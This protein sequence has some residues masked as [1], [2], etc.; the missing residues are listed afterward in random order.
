[1]K[2]IFIAFALTTFNVQ[3]AAMKT[4]VCLEIFE[5]NY[6]DKDTKLL[7]FYESKSLC[8]LNTENTSKEEIRNLKGKWLT[9]ISKNKKQPIVTE[10]MNHLGLHDDCVNAIDNDIMHCPQGKKFETISKYRN[11]EFKFTEVK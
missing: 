7:S 4:N 1:M 8:G 10:S 6:K 5:K 9:I 3:A 2:F 11:E